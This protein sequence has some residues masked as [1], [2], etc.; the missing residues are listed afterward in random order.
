LNQPVD[1]VA[2]AQ[3]T[4]IISQLAERIADNPDKPSWYEESFY[5][6]LQK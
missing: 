6:K 3:F 1:P 5:R 2:A 4:A